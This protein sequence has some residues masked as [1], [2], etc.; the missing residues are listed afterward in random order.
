VLALALA[1]PASA[2]AARHGSIRG[3]TRK[4]SLSW[5]CGVS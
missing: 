1:A 5:A 3:V 2:S 4:R